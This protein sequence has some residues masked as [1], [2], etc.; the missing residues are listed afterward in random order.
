MKKR[1]L[2][3]LIS[4]VGGPTPRS[5]AKA[6]RD[7]G[8]Y[9]DYRLIGTDI[10]PFTIGLYD[11]SL[12]DKCY[13]TKRSS[14]E[15]YWEEM[16]ALIA[17]EKI[18][19][20]IIMP[21]TEVLAWSKRQ[22]EGVLPCKSLIP[23]VEAIEKMLDK[24]VLTETLKN[25]GLVPK[26]VLI[27]ANN[28]NLQFDTEKVLTYPYWI[29]SATGSS[30]LG[31]FKVQ[32]YDD[33][34]MWISINKGIDNFIASEYL[35]GR[36][37]ACKMLYYN[38]KLVRSAMAE[39]VNY[40]MGKISPSG[41]TG[42]TSF[43]RLINDKKVFDVSNSAMEALFQATGAERHGFFTVDLKE[44]EDGVP[45]VTEVNVRHVAFTQCI[46]KGGANL[47]ED[48]VRLLDEDTSFDTNFH[49]YQYS[50]NWVFLRDVD[51]NPI[52]MKEDEL[53]QPFSVPVSIENQR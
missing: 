49:L 5:F 17:L 6:I 26:S 32:S 38:G 53:L 39:R 41:I 15:G 45:M 30:G 43:G 7:F 19:L 21:E 14:D 13:L 51:E 22:K 11:N 4:G 10:H 35:P 42:N 18:D 2:T 47:C 16:E 50:E 12:F 20:A 52:L 48:T 33:L 40:I 27:D 29:R 44:N 9:G 31:S 8:N 36:N 34:T 24:G 25:T 46:A 3:I 28:P 1:Q 37:L 23:S